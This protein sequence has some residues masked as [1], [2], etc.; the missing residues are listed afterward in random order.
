MGALRYNAWATPTTR[1]ST[2]S[3]GSLVTAFSVEPATTSKWV[4]A[5]TTMKRQ[6]EEPIA[7]ATSV[8]PIRGSPLRRKWTTIDERREC[9]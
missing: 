1:A 8:L 4:T 9:L 6:T 7:G 5:I 2:S 3:Q